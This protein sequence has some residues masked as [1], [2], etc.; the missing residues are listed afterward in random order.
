M[1]FLTKETLRLGYKLVRFSK[2]YQKKNLS[3]SRVLPFAIYSPWLDDAEFQKIYQHIAKEYTLVDEYRCFEL[4][5][6]IEQ[7]NKLDSSAN[8]LEVGVWRGGTSTVMAK[9]LQLLGSSAKIY[10][11]DT[12]E[13]V[14]KTSS[15]DSSYTGGE[16]ADT[17]LDLFTNL[18]KSLNLTN[19]IPLKGIFPDQ[20]A[21]QIPG[22]TR[23][24]LCH[25]DVD[26]YLSAKDVQD[27][28]WNKLIIGGVVVFDDYGFGSTDGIT[29]FVNE[30]RKLSD[31][32]VLHNLN[33]HAV[34]IKLT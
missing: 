16:H 17:S 3:Y 18:F 20:T 13:G 10:S 5:Q 26:V 4:W 29:N 15:K 14:V 2:P 24:K 7:T 28:I 19:I 30:Q 12:F 9:Q 1:N 21:N 22:E 27:W 11:A 8:V 33:G 6:L 25:I 23:F 31:R 32:I 34:I